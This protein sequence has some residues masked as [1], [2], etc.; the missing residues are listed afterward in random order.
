MPTPTLAEVLDFEAEHPGSGGVKAT[1]ISERFGIVPVRYYQ[2]L[3]Q[4]IRTTEALLHD[5]VLTNRVR[6][7]MGARTAARAERRTR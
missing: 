7:Q 4:Y 2:L 6:A 3:H 1:R 5:P